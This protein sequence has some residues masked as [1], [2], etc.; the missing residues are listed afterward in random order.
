MVSLSLSSRLLSFCVSSLTA[1]RRPLKAALVRALEFSE[2]MAVFPTVGLDKGND[3][4][5]KRGYFEA[6]SKLLGQWLTLSADERHKN[7][8]L[9]GSVRQQATGRKQLE[10]E[11]RDWAS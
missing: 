3:I 7:I 2:A 1:H 11:D 6:R 10:N 8:W 5:E 4:P 9:S